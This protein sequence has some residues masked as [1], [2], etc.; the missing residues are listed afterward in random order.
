MK[1][2]LVLAA[3]LVAFCETAL[4]D[5]IGPYVYGSL[6]SALATINKAQADSQV[7]AANGGASV[8]SSVKGDPLFY[9]MNLGYQL[10][11]R[12]GLQL[13]Y[14]STSSFRYSTAAPIASEA[15]KRLQ[16][17][18]LNISSS[19]L[20]GG[21]F[22]LVIRG[23]VANVH[24]TGSGTTARFSRTDTQGVGGA[25]LKYEIDRHL[26]VRLDW[27]SFK[28]PGG[29]QIGTVNTV[30]AGIGYNF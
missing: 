2:K 30:G 11:A 28:G 29:S 9:Q 19:F 22:E 13:G 27:D 6:G 20:L 4:A 24:A 26:S 1:S 10:L 7:S 15:S 23:G 8:Q 3:G 5:D 14:G 18:A 16:V 12:V 17:L 21:G 25:S